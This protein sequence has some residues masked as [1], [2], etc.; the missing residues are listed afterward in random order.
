MEQLDAAAAEQPRST[1]LGQ[2]SE[3]SYQT[4]LADPCVAADDHGSGVA[5]L[6]SPEGRLKLAELLEAAHEAW[7]GDSLRLGAIVADERS[8]CHRERPQS[9][10]QPGARTPS[11]AGR[12]RLGRGTYQSVAASSAKIRLTHPLCHACLAQV[13]HGVHLLASVFDDLP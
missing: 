1:P 13:V 3:L 9:A 12:P 6:S 2:P 11:L 7:T 5:F 8:P 4:C 10:A